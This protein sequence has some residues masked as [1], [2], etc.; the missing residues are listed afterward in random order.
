MVKVRNELFGMYVKAERMNYLECIPLIF[1]LL[2]GSANKIRFTVLRLFD[3]FF[4]TN[5]PFEQTKNANIYW[6]K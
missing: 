5:P 1:C 4:L 3:N 2:E 6:I